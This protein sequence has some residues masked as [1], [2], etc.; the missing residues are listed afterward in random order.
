MYT[1][2]STREYDMKVEEIFIKCLK[3]QYFT[4]IFAYRRLKLRGIV[5]NCVESLFLSCTAHANMAAIKNAL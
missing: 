5:W 1:E 3:N 2:E 4:I